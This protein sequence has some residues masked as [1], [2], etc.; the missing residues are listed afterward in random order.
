MLRLLLITCGFSDFRRRAFLIVAS[1]LSL[2]VPLASNVDAVRRALALGTPVV[3]VLAD[4]EFAP[5]PSMF[6]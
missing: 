2:I 4:R 3:A 1:R 5:K 6:Q